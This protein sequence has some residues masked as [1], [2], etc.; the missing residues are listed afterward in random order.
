MALTFYA[1]E[2]ETEGHP[3]FVL[4]GFL[5]RAEQWALFSDDWKAV[6][7]EPP[8]IPAFHMADCWHNGTSRLLPK[9][10][11]VIKTHHILGF[12]VSLDKK[13]FDNV[14]VGKIAKE[15]DNLYVS[16]LNFIISF[17]I[18][19][20][21]DNGINERVDFVF[22]EKNELSGKIQQDYK[23]VLPMLDERIASRLLSI[24]DFLKDDKVRPLQ[25]ADVLA[26]S[27]RRR[28][29]F[30]EDEA[31]EKGL[32]VVRVQREVP[33][34]LARFTHD[35]FADLLDYIN[36]DA[37]KTGKPTPYQAKALND[38]LDLIIH[39]WNTV[40]IEKS[41][42]GELIPMSAFPATQ[43]GRFRLLRKCP[44]CDTPHLHKRKG[45]ECLGE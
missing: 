21:I 32:F 4:A 38:N 39:V 3:S 37:I 7:D 20:Q 17:V 6:L 12:A 13:E 29:I 43:M 14:I 36:L 18:K 26:W 30:Q 25:A 22:D 16:A 45:G 35:N 15:A 44:L 24:P 10:L 2:S 8:A 33:I 31:S 28:D 23:K 34:L 27:I 42:P 1:D 41:A 40:R 5:A 19:W 11:D 9:L